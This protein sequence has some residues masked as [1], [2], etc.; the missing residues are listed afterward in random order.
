ML[1]PSFH[2]LK[3]DYQGYF[4]LILDNKDSKFLNSI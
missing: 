2:H 4:K 3:V 1:H